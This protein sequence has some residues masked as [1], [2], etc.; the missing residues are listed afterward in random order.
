M[1]YVPLVAG[2]MLLSYSSVQAIGVWSFGSFAFIVGFGEI[3]DS[4]LCGG[5]VVV[6]IVCVLRVVE[7]V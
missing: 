1:K 5:V 6:G 7:V 4:E 2:P 3:V